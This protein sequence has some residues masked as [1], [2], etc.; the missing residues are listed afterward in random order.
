M[1]YTWN[2]TPIGAPR[3]TRADAWKQRPV[4]IRYHIFRDEVF[5]LM[6][7]TKIKEAEKIAVDF[8]IPMAKSWSKKKKEIMCN[9]PHKL[10]PD[11]DNL[12]KALLDAI[13]REGDDC[14]VWDIHARKFWTN[15]DG[16][17]ELTI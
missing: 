3:M 10:K 9:T 13:H 1:K 12:V 6:A 7:K 17:I 16:R 11:I 5:I 8:Y 15:E 14:R 2:I 4:V